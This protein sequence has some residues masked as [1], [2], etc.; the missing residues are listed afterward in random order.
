MMYW[1]YGV[2][3]LMICFLKLPLLHDGKPCPKRMHLLKRI[4]HS[5]SLKILDSSTYMSLLSMWTNKQWNQTASKQKWK[6]QIEPLTFQLLSLCV[7]LYNLPSPLAVKKK[8]CNNKVQ[9]L[10]CIFYIQVKYIL[11]YKLE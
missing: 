4:G 5:N 9:Y 2:T 6:F 3:F 10:M 8:A 11:R 7:C 1:E